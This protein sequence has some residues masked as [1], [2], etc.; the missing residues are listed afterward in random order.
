MGNDKDKDNDNVKTNTVIAMEY[1]PESLGQ[2]WTTTR[3]MTR[4]I[5]VKACSVL[6][7]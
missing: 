4:T 6:H 7:R 2:V 3:T 1:M 5:A